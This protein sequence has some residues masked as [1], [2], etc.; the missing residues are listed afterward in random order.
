MLIKAGPVWSYLHNVL[1]ELIAKLD[2]VLSFEVKGAWF[3]PR[4][5]TLIASGAWDGR[6]HFYSRTTGRFPTGLL[7][8]VKEII[9]FD[10]TDEFQDNRFPKDYS[11]GD[12]VDRAKVLELNGISLAGHQRE[13]IINNVKNGRGL[14]LL[15]TNAGKSEVIV[16]TAMAIRRKTLWLVST[17]D[18]LL[19]CADRF[20]LRTGLK[21][22]IV[23]AGQ[24][25]VGDI[26]TVGMVQTINAREKKWKDFLAQF[27]VLMIDE[28]QHA[29][30]VTWFTIANNCNASFRFG[31][32]GSI[33][34][35][36][37]KAHRIKAVT[38]YNI[39][40]E[41]SNKTLIEA[42]WSAKPT[43]HIRPVRF[44]KNRKNYFDAYNDMINDHNG[45]LQ[46]VLNDIVEW[47]DRDKVVL[48]LVERKYQGSRISQEL[49]GRGIKCVYI[50]GNHEGE[51][52]KKVLDK[53][54][55]GKIPIL[56]ATKILGEGVDV[57]SIQVLILPACGKSP[58][59]QL[60][61]IGRA[62]RKKAED[63]KADVVDYL[64]LGNEFLEDHSQERVELYADEGFD[65]DFLPEVRLDK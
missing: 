54:R 53:F 55:G 21:A 49:G 8:R 17:K 46:V 36:E 20:N 4:L 60:Q 42:G 50:H 38:D 3:N 26:M 58:Q 12:A 25:S 28:C 14:N 11:W 44:P 57:P 43:F 32:S 23:G 64:I 18:L 45:Y 48:V 59:R 39:I 22:G 30:A 52:R 40:S 35:D 34:K 16:G 2:N 13:S 51:Y 65:I 5:R 6:T 7:S 33:P 15:A 10:E 61:R 56:I 1:P 29:Q 37:T 27:E 24:F 47:Y 9:G 19:Q 63:N 62:L 41:I 31:L